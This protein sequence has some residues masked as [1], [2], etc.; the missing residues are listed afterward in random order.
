[1]AVTIDGTSGITMPAGGLANTAGAAV[2]TTDS[3][4]L[5]NKTIQGGALTLATA[6]T[7]SGTAVDFTAIPSWV[8][9]ITVALVAVSTNGSRQMRI[10]L[11]TSAGVETT[12]YSGGVAYAGAAQS[13]V[14]DIDG[15]TIY[16][17]GNAGNALSG[18]ATFVKVSGNTWAGIGVISNSTF[19][20]TTMSGAS[21]T[22]AGVLDRVRITMNGSDAF[23]AGTINIMYEG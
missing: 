3:Q 6:V 17:F 19:A 15:M 5:T 14:T 1:M 16:L 8:K 2:G 20:Y 23:D 4:T 13:G 22:L 9:R 18:T 21:K 7:A 12:G 10:Q 11:G